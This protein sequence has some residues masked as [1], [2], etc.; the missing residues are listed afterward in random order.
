[1][2]GGI[3]APTGKSVEE[4]VDLAVSGIKAEDLL[5]EG[6]G[7][8]EVVHL[9]VETSEGEESVEVGGLEGEGSLE[10][11]DGFLPVVV[12]VN[13]LGKLAQKGGVAGGG[14]ACEGHFCRSAV[15]DP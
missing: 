5:A 14:S 12:V 15:A 10:N 6:F 7:G 1:M 9:P 8:G 3:T 4:I 2:G 11:G 13:A